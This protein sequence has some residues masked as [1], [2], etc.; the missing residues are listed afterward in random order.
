MPRNAEARLARLEQ[1]K[2][3]HDEVE[4]YRFKRNRLIL[5]MCA[6]IHLAA[7]AAGMDPA[8]IAV[9]RM[10]EEAEQALIAI[11]DT[12]E[13]WQA[14]MEAAVEEERVWVRQHPGEARPQNAFLAELDS[15]AL[16]FAD[17]SMPTNEDPLFVWYAWA[18]KQPEPPVST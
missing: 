4:W 18:R 12:T 17:G 9:L 8:G 6:E 11:G 7:T 5:L 10:G 13:A 2:Q 15:I 3:W 1:G 16:R 14:D